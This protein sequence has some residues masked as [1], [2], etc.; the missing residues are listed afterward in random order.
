MINLD[1]GYRS[2][3]SFFKTS[4]V[5]GEFIIN[6]RTAHPAKSNKKISA[7]FRFFYLI[8]GSAFAIIAKEIPT[9]PLNP[10]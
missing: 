4:P 10:P 9:A 5:V 7:N 3:S 2:K 1:E 8:N 6:V